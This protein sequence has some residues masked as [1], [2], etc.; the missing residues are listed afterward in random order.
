VE[1][2]SVSQKKVPAIPDDAAQRNIVQQMSKY[3]VEFSPRFP[4]G[5]KLMYPTGPGVCVLFEGDDPI[6][7]C[8]TENVAGRVRS[9]LKT[10]SSPLRKALGEELY[11]GVLGGFNAD[12]NKVFSKEIESQLD[13]FMSQR[14]LVAVHPL[15]IGRKEVEE[16]VVR[17]YRPF[18]NP[19]VKNGKR[20]VR[21]VLTP[22]QLPS[23]LL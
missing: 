5:P 8:A 16:F 19:G 3:I 20:P 7:V 18:Y 10:P 1:D 23:S 2:D 6:Y 11:N 22:F 9:L 4:L 21:E 13:F 12:S 17:Q 15:G 14:V